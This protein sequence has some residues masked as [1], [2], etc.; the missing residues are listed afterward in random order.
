[1]RINYNS[2]S[3]WDPKISKN[4]TIRGHM[5]MKTP[6]KEKSLFIHTLIFSKSNGIDNIYAYFPDVKVLLGYI[7][8]SFLQEA[9]YK[10]IYGREKVVTNIPSLTVDK[11]VNIG[12]SEGKV[13]KEEAELMLGYYHKIENMW[14]LTDNKLIMELVKFARLFNKT[15][16]GNNKEFL[17]LKVFK[18]AEEVGEFVINSILTTGDSDSFKDKI[19]VGIDE[20]RII[21]KNATTNVEVGERFKE[22]FQKNL[23]EI[24]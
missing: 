20:W 15:W 17:Y 3:Y 14:E 18:N 11:I 2:F 4:K 5:F 10:W 7:Q 22:I 1:M 16:Y 19:G 8:Y 9:F 6:P 12:L 13:S 23:T 21:C 24:I